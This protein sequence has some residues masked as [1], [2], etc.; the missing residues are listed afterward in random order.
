MVLDFAYQHNENIIRQISKPEICDSTKYLILTNNTIN[1]LN[2]V[3]HHSNN[4]S[5]KYD[6][7]FSV[8]NQNSTARKRMLKNK[9]LNPI[10]D[11]DKLNSNYDLTE[12]MMIRENQIYKYK[13]FESYLIKINDIE[14]L[15]R[16]ISLG[17]LQP[18][19]F[20]V[21]DI[22]YKNI[23]K[24]LDIIKTDS[25]NFKNISICYLKKIQ[26]IN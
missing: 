2:V 4:F 8:V 13:E 9:I 14:R 16:K 26:L 5:G 18:A 22:S 6:S 15:H 19:D 12:Y 10:I 17:V 1:Q 7:L 3:N 24:M 11:I 23:L 20:G 21:L 25:N